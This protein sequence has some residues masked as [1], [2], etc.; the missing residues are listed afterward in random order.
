MN[1]CNNLIITQDLNIKNSSSKGDLR[2]VLNRLTVMK[3]ERKPQDVS[4]KET[5][6]V[7]SVRHQRAHQSQGP[8][9]CTVTCSVSRLRPRVTEALVGLSIKQ[10]DSS[11]KE[12]MDMSSSATTGWRVKGGLSFLLDGYLPV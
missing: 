9:P 11:W 10:D 8:S 6:T 12:E 5:R 7:Q 3:D 2:N 4:H 1:L